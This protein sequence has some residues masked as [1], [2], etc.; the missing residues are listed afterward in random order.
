M[1]LFKDQTTVTYMRRKTEVP[2]L[3]AGR[4]DRASR[5]NRAEIREVAAHDFSCDDPLPRCDKTACHYWWPFPWV[6]MDLPTSAEPY[7]RLLQ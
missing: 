1:A 2:T 3:S 5:L 4:Y 7:C 6:E